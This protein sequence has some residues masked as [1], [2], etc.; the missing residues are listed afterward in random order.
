MPSSTS[1]DVE[2]SIQIVPQTRAV[3]SSR[4]S[5][6]DQP[7]NQRKR[8][9]GRSPK[10]DI[11]SI[12]T[13]SVAAAQGPISEEVITEEPMETQDPSRSPSVA[14]TPQCMPISEVP[15]DLRPDTPPPATIPSPPSVVVPPP[16]SRGRN[17]VSEPQAPSNPT[18]QAHVMPSPTVSQMPR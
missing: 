7:P 16:P 1:V 11:R 15:Q 6:F 3:I 13:R 12:V 9:R 2:G 17:I 14:P 8:K 4:S 18:M 5:S 10:G